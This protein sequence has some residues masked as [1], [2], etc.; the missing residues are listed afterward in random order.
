MKKF[1]KEQW[2]AI[3]GIVFGIA[4]GCTIG[5]CMYAILIQGA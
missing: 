2:P 4:A 1:L 5:Y 3:L